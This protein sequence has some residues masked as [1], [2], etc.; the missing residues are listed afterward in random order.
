MAAAIRQLGQT[1]EVV[2]AAAAAID[3]ENGDGCGGV[4]DVDASPMRLRTALLLDLI[5]SIFYLPD[6]DAGWKL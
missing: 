4:V 6:I 3:D 2:A 1:K 5:L